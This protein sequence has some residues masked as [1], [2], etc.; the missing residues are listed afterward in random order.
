MAEEFTAKFRV[1]I[2]DLKKNITEANKQIKLANATFKAETAGMEDWTKD[3]DGLSSKLKQLGTVLNE[4]KS[5][6]S[7]YKTQLERQKEAYDENGKRAD[8]LKAKLKQLAENGVSKTSEEYKSYRTALQNVVK[9][10]QNNEKAIDDLNITILEQESTVKKT[11]AE[12]GRYET[13]LDELDDTFDDLDESAG[14][15]SDG[16]T[17]LKGALADLVADA[18][19]KAIDALKDFVKETINVGKE[20]DSSMSQVEAVSGATGEELDALREKAKEMGANTKFSAS[21]VADGFNYMAMAGWKTEDMLDGIEGVLN[22]AAASGTDLATTSD[23][24]TDALTAMGY[25]AEDA[26]RLADVMAAASSNANTNVEMMGGTFKYAAP[27]V[28]ALGYSM[29]DTAVAIGMMANAGI[30]GEQA[31]TALRSVLSRLASPPKEAATAM[32]ALGLSI[33]E[34]DGTMKPLNQVI[35]EMR[36]AFSGLTESEQAQYAKQIAGTEAMSGF[37]AIVNGAPADLDKLRDA[38]DNSEGAAARMA[39]TMQDNLGGDLTKFGSQLEGV[40]IALYEKFEPALRKGVEILGGFLKGIQ[41]IIDHSTE[42]ITVLASMAAGLATYFAYTTA[43][44]VMKNGWMSLTIVQKAVAAGQALLNAVMEANPI[45]LLIAAI[46]ALVTAFVI[47]W[48][49]SEGFREFWIGLWENIKEIAGSV[50]EWFSETWQTVI[51]WFA[52]A[53]ESIKGFFTSAW[54][55]ISEVWNTVAE[56][57]DTNVIQPILTF[58]TELWNAV[59][60]VFTTAWNAIKKVWNVVANWF[61]TKIVKPIMKFFSPLFNWFK[62]LFTSI[63]MTIKT[64]FE[65]IAQL[66]Q[67]CV[68]LVKAIWKVVSGWFNDKVIKPIK[69]FFTNLWNAVK[70]TAKNAWEG[71]KKIWKVVSTWFNDKIIKPVKK[72]FTELWNAVKKKASDAWNKIKEVWNVVSGWFNEH[73]VTPVKTAFSGLWKSVKSAA[74][75]A[76]NGIKSVW[77]VVSGWFKTKIVTP[78]KTAFSGAWNAVKTGAKNAWSGIKSVFTAVPNWF[79]EKFSNAWKKVKQVFST[80]GKVF[81][82]IKEG[83]TDAFKTVVNAIIKG[84]N[85]VIAI[86]FNAINKVLGKIRNV[87]IAGIKPF[88]RLIS[89]IS[90]PQIPLLAKGGILQKGQLGLLEG[91]GAEA[92]VPLDRNKAWV[93]A[94]ASDMLDELTG[95]QSIMNSSNNSRVANFTQII[96][97]PKSPTR[98][99]LYRQTRNLLAFAST[100][101]GV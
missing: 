84:I 33:T 99:E 91:S 32:E 93:R 30:K 1:D 69:K 25:S 64:T 4:Q 100:N 77:N 42:F 49:K 53:W 52:G 96:N 39:E 13:S 27:L 29:E 78:V 44:N 90:V 92:V 15:A 55:S 34:A 3:A 28:G 80:G 70:T 83:I 75:T 76:W 62:K 65:V 57:F 89:E 46:T 79:K 87:S 36:T 101:G 73:I 56:W 21:E 23:I 61:N 67:G 19:R 38:V 18:I 35:D 97:A 81:D 58:F 11:E 51:D 40:Q 82:G 63:W 24:V 10:Q 5:K 45:G 95:N 12:I 94:V 16:F 14:N 20:F 54:E 37:L 72:V 59:T 22:L 26:G 9:E 71:I 43:I 86:P 88:S 85:K 74:S 66:A 6:L 7:A 48:N 60:E 50:A 47:L 8:Q 98:I 17:V 41:F 31:G 68:E 2:S